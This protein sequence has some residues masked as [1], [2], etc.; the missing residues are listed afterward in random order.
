MH[1]KDAFT[2]RMRRAVDE[3]REERRILSCR[4]SGAGREGGREERMFDCAERKMKK[5]KGKERE[6]MI[7]F[8]QV[9]WL[10]VC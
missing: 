1:S 4:E 9:L 8:G 10:A 2:L 5:W 7:G 6:C 3:R